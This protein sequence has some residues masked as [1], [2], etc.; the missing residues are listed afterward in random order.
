[1]SK[2]DYGTTELRRQFTVVPKLSGPTTMT[3]KV[4]DESEI[5]RLL[6]RDAI[7]PSQHATLEGLMR[8]LH[9][10]GFI[11]LKSPA[12]DS[13]IHAD[14]SAV[15]DRKA[16]LIRSTVMLFAR[17]DKKIGPPRRK[18]LVDLVLADVPWPGDDQS[19]LDIISQLDDVIAGR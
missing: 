1:M 7:K 15:G 8:R 18:A 12:Y 11:G 5:D 10:A 6:M 19:L 13:P 14:A 16:N 3:F 2:H 4:V 17:L 9:K